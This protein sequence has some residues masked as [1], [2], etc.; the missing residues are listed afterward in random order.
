[1]NKV[2]AFYLTLLGMIIMLWY[3][4]IVAVTEY[5]F[6]R[7]KAQTTLC[8]EWLGAVP[9]HVSHETQDAGGS[10]TARETRWTKVSNALEWCQENIAESHL[11]G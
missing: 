9:G 11:L 8:V 10:S 1:M 2:S 4:V 3:N 5:V 6:C 7:D